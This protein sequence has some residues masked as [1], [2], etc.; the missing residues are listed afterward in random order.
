MSM[1]VFWVAVQFG[2]TSRHQ[3]F[4]GTYCLRRQSPL[5]LATISLTKDGGR[6]FLR[7]FGI[8]TKAYTTL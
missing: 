4:V 1:L 5:L 7:N 6:I 8:Y 3:C 2:A